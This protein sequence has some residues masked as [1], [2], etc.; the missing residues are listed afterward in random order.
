MENSIF[1]WSI[2]N[3]PGDTTELI[4]QT[5][6]GADLQRKFKAHAALGGLRMKDLHAEAVE[7]YLQ[8]RASLMKGGRRV[9]YLVANEEEGAEVNVTIPFTLMRKAVEAAE[10][11]NVSTR[12]FLYM[13]L[14]HYFEQEKLAQGAEALD[15]SA[16]A[17]KPPKRR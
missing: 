9:Q 16:K 1:P 5:R 7:K 2:G 12:R 3:M 14:I 8:Y 17:A 6:I 15:A 10:E 11:D 13:A 4:K